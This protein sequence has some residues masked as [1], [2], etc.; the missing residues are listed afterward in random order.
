MNSII[1][2]SEL[3]NDSDT[4]EKDRKD[5]VTIIQKNCDKLLNFID[6]LLDIS[7]IE[8]GQ[9]QINKSQC[10]IN[11][12]LDEIYATFSVIK[13]RFGKQQIGLSLKKH[14]DDPNFTIYSDSYRLQQILLNLIGNAV[15]FTNIGFVEMGYTIQELNN[16]ITFYVKDTGIGIPEDKF[17]LIFARFG[18][19]E[20]NERNIDGTGL[21]LAI[22]KN[23]VELLGGSISV[24]SKIGEG[25]TFYVELP[26]S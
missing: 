17:E 16:T 23:L 10:K 13:N 15:K 14:T 26:L 20:Q 24:K 1:G 19:V 21:G 4:S 2:F 11:I 22:S 8:A 7:V 3:L 12:I 18:Q 9:V 5:Y 25:S 6:N